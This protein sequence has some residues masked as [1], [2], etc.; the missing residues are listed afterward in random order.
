MSPYNVA[1]GITLGNFT[2]G[3]LYRPKSLDMPDLCLTPIFASD[4]DKVVS[5][6]ITH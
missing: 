6:S 5:A 2:V 3:R 4:N 1:S